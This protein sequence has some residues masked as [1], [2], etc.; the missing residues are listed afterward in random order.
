MSYGG[1]S[2]HDWD[3]R[4]KR[5]SRYL[6]DHPLGGASP[7]N[8]PRGGGDLV[9]VSNARKQGA[10]H[11]EE[12]LKTQEHWLTKNLRLTRGGLPPRGRSRI[13]AQFGRGGL[14][15]SAGQ[16]AVNSEVVDAH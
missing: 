15:R 6:P 1:S 2:L 10:R 12:S 8:R 4:S 13:V 16:H 7:S 9:I 14:P 5:L 11:N 3:A